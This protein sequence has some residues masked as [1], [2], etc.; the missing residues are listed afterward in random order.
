MK[1][2]NVKRINYLVVHYLHESVPVWHQ[3]LL[4]YVSLLPKSRYHVRFEVRSEVKI[5]V[6]NLRG[7][8]HPEI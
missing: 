6:V 7:M 4:E 1:V 8:T 3:I 2:L 5:R